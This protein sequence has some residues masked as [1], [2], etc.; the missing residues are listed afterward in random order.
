M[1]TDMATELRLAT[2]PSKLALWQA[3]FTSRSLSRKGYACRIETISSR[4]DQLPDQPLR[5]FAGKGAFVGSLETALLDGQVDGAVHSLKD[6]SVNLT[7]PLALT[8]MM[9]RHRSEDV[10]LV[11]RSGVPASLQTLSRSYKTITMNNIDELRF[12]ENLTIATSS[13]RRA[14]LLT[15][16]LPGC[17]MSPIR[18]NVDTRLRKIL[19]P[20]TS[21]P[22]DA[23][24]LSAACLTRLA[25]S[26]REFRQLV[27]SFIIYRLSPTWFIPSPG[28]GALTVQTLSSHPLYHRLQ[29]LSCPSTHAATMIERTITRDLGGHCMLPLGC[30]AKLSSPPDDSYGGDRVRVQ[31]RAVLATPPRF[32]FGDFFFKKQG[33]AFSPPSARP[34]T[35]QDHQPQHGAPSSR[36]RRHALA[37]LDEYL[38]KLSPQWNSQSE[39]E[40]QGHADKIS[41]RILHKLALEGAQQIY[42]DLGLTLPPSWRPP[43]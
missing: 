41:A 37:E 7:A 2:R 29:E 36:E 32:L 43:A 18:G 8:M 25:R 42:Q 13:P 5:D 38:P 6:L 35:P 3:D 28:Q 12:L 4:G 17:R 39:E 16:A 21:S 22:G 24:I 15:H 23:L 19:T 31:V 9:N 14:A 11:P 40:W 26:Q 1:A 33:K 34:A 10:L 20:R 30:L 27:R